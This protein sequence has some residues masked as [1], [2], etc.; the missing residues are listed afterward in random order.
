MSDDLGEAGR[1]PQH[2]LEVGRVKLL[3]Q[4][5]KVGRQ[6]RLARPA[7]A[8]GLTPSIAT[9]PTRAP[10]ETAPA[11]ANSRAH[12]LAE[13]HRVRV[14]RRDQPGVR[15][16]RPPA[17]RLLRR[18]RR[19]RHHHGPRTPSSARRRLRQGRTPKPSGR[20]KSRAGEADV[21]A[22][23]VPLASGRR[24]CGRKEALARPRPRRNKAIASLHTS[25]RAIARPIHACSALQRAATFTQRPRAC[26]AKFIRRIHGKEGAPSPAL[27]AW[28]NSRP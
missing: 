18:E 15:G 26:A 27:T 25:R 21:A 13:H 2:R 8:A 20:S 24:S 5:S 19:R 6:C 11:P 3:V 4:P 17:R 22:R 10:R 1:L 23:A 7:D 28:A 12:Q 14:V 9:P 16:R